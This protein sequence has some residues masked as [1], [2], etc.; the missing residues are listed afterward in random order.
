MVLKIS[1]ML[2]RHR[3]EDPSVKLC[4]EVRSAQAEAAQ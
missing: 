4:P 3:E 1:S 2:L